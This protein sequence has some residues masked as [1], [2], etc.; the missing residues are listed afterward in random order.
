[1]KQKTINRIIR[2]KVSAW[3]KSITD[4]SLRNELKENVL[5]SGGC[6]TSLFL[7]ENV[8]DY[9][10][11]I[12]SPEVLK[13]LCQYYVDEFSTHIKSSVKDITLTVQDHEDSH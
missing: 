11:Y 7:K 6:I 3:I 1:M 2:K 10:I 5:V 9:D 4:E 13:R 12:K 8:N